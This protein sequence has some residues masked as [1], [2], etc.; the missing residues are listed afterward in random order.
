MSHLMLRGGCAALAL[1]VATPV[2]AQTPSA[3]ELAALVK[4]QA[5]EIATLK[6]RLD[7]LEG[8]QAVAASTPSV[9]Q[10]PAP[11][12]AQQGAIQPLV[13]TPSRRR[14]CRPAP[15]TST[16]HRPAPWPP[17]R[18]ASPPNGAL[19]CPSSAH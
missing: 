2:L 18:P 17:I 15:Q 7:K 3:D 4:A 6:A 1:I 14:S 9:P 19:A 12:M 8:Q 11:Q 13:I 5:A 10:Q 16:W